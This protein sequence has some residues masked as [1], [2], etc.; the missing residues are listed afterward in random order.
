M[1]THDKYGI[2]ALFKQVQIETPRV[3]EIG[4]GRLYEL[5]PTRC[6]GRQALVLDGKD[7]GI[8]VALRQEVPENS[9]LRG[10]AT[11][12]TEALA[13]LGALTAALRA[14]EVDAE[15]IGGR[16]GLEAVLLSRRLCAREPDADKLNEHLDRLQEI[17]EALEPALTLS[18]RAAIDGVLARV[19]PQLAASPEK[20]ERRQAVIV[21]TFDEEARDR[22]LRELG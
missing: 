5:E 13:L 10:E 22:M 20:I 6:G 9:P 12:S 8:T 4:A 2:E 21:P 19:R 16:E 7:K 14:Q 1:T 11:T 15:L 3:T 17:A 18:G